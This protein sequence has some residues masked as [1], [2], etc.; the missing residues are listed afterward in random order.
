MSQCRSLF[1]C[2]LYVDSAIGSN[3]QRAVSSLSPTGGPVMMIKSKVR[4]IIN[5]LLSCALGARQIAI[6]HSQ[7][8]LQDAFT[9]VWATV[10][11]HMFCIRN[12]ISV[13]TAFELPHHYLSNLLDLQH[14]SLLLGARRRAIS[15]CGSRRCLARHHLCHETLPTGLAQVSC[16]SKNVILHRELCLVMLR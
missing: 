13:N 11:R 1:E 3:S 2:T 10:K 12:Q 5:C 15:V 8:A 6:S 16:R 4:L 14:G 7:T 9:Q